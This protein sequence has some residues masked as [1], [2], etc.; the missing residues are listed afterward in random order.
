MVDGFD[1]KAFIETE[2]RE[3]QAAQQD[4][5]RYWA[6]QYGHEAC[7]M[8][9]QGGGNVLYHGQVVYQLA[10]HAAHYGAI[11]LESRIDV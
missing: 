6:G 10:R 2:V 11:A 5:P 3:K 4:W 9:R 1:A 7:V 8:A